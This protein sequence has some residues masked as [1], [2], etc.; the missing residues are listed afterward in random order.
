VS[1]ALAPRAFG[2]GPLAGYDL[3]RLIHFD[4]SGIGKI[5]LEPYVVVAGVITEPDRHS[6]LVLNYLVQIALDYVP[7]EKVDD[8]VCFHAK[9]LFHGGKIFDREKWPFE[10]RLPIIKR[11][12]KIPAR[13][14]LPV[15]YGVVSR[16]TVLR[17]L[18]PDLARKERADSAYVMAFLHA[19]L[20]SNAWMRN[21]ARPEEV[22]MVVMENNNEMRQRLRRAQ[23]WVRF[24]PEE[25]PSDLQRYLPLE[26]II[27][28]VLFA[29]K[30]ESSLL[31]IADMCAYVIRRR[32]ANLPGSHELFELIAPA[33]QQEPTIMNDPL[34]PALTQSLDGVIGLS[35]S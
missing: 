3:M 5:E 32:I 31:Q 15:V 19:L 34:W 6:R 24:P 16:E 2:R 12:L 28:S 20:R 10:K 8:F 21:T 33:I 13:F 26:R 4:E 7:P 17:N 35:S 9:E 11:I 23:Q 25:M 29:E 22:A 18:L 27:E 14:G 30:H 1:G